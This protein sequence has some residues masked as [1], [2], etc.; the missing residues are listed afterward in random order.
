MA[1]GCTN[2]YPDLTFSIFDRYGR[3]IAKYRQGQ[4]W[5]GTMERNYLLRLLYTLKLNNNKDDREF[6]RSL[7][8]CIG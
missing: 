5:N 7:L 4:K 3:V 1:P 2:N 6:C 8:H